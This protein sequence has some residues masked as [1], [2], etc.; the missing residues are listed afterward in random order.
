MFKPYQTT[1]ATV[2]LCF[3]LNS[4]KDMFQ[5]IVH[6]MVESRCLL[7]TN[8]RASWSYMWFKYWCFVVEFQQ[9]FVMYKI[10]GP[11]LR[12]P[13]PQWVGWGHYQPQG[14][15]GEDLIWGQ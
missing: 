11:V 8:L 9:T 4:G 1:C 15:K 2:I 14:G 5:I 7:G 3:L 6:F 10:Y 12:P 13:P